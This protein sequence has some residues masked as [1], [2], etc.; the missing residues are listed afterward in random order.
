MKFFRCNCT[1]IE[2]GIEIA[3]ANLFILEVKLHSMN[4]EKIINLTLDLNIVLEGFKLDRKKDCLYLLNLKDL[5]DDIQ[6]TMTKLNT[7]F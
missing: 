7:Q 1:H 4:N 2:E 3:N 6:Y 5:N